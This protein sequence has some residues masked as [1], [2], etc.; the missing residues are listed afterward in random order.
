MSAGSQRPVLCVELETGIGRSEQERIRRELL[1]LGQAYPHTQGISDDPL[2]PGLPGR[3]PP[4]RQDLPREAGGLGREEAWMKALV[5][6][7][8]GFLGGAI[9]RHA[10]SSG[11]MRSA[12]F[13]AA[14]IPRWPRSASSRSGA[15]WPTGRRV[16]AAPQGCDIV[17]HVAAKA[18]I[19]GAYEDYYRANVT[20]TETCSPPAGPTASAG[21]STPARRAWSS[22]AATWRGATN[23]SPIPH[24]YEAHY[25][26]TKALAEQLVLAANCPEPGHRRRSART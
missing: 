16:T 19:W 9:V 23:R 7:G 2:P 14:T 1:E 26:E 18:G 21:W 10:A 6:G 15:T 25:P 17:F 3:Y 8:G 20:G 11:A 12:A 4:Q 24:H 22:T 13:P 5:T